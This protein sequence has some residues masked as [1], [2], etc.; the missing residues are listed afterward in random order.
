MPDSQNS[1]E[2]YRKLFTEIP[3]ST[4]IHDIN[5]GEIIDANPAAYTSFGY[6]SLEE[7]QAN[8]IWSEPPYSI[9]DAQEW[10]KKAISKGPQEFEWAHKIAGGEIMW[11]YVRLSPVVINGVQRVMSASINITERK[12]AEQALQEKTKE[13]E[14]SHERFIMAVNGSQ[15]GIWDWDMLTNEVFFSSRWKEMIGY[16]E[17]EL[18]NSFS[19]FEE[20]IHPEDKQRVIDQLEKYLRKEIPEYKVEFQ[21]EHKDGNYTWI[22]ARGTAQWDENGLPYRMSG[23]HTDITERRMSVMELQRKEVQLRTA[24]SVGSIGSWEFDLN[25]RKVDASEEARKIYGIEEKE[26]N[27]DEIQ[28]IPLPEYRPILL[29]TMK[30]LLDKNIPYDVEFKI[31]RPNDGEIRY[32]HSVAEYFAERNVVIGTIQDITESKKN[33]MALIQAKAL[34]EESNQIK[35]EFI[36][37]MSHELRTPL[38]SVIGFSQI[39][40]EKIYGNLNEKQIRYVSNILKSGTHLLELINDILDISKIESGNMDYEPEIINIQ[41]VINEIVVLMDPL[42]KEKMLDFEASIE[43]G[44]PDVKAD[45][46]KIKQIVY[47]LLSNAIKFTPEKGKVWLDSKTINGKVRISVSDNGIGIPFEQQKVIFDPFKQVNSASNRTHGG[48]GLGLA[49]VKYYV[50]MHS[51]EIQVES[52][53]G[54]GSTF[55]FTLPVDF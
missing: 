14:K 34:A 36:A 11:L 27:V 22:L 51:G 39:L 15:D 52:E 53:P 19:A 3:I 5:S 17:H 29:E 43:N 25:F 55:T 37:N 50:E 2:Q 6:S 7:L 42:I 41:E 35:S 21:L 23:S 8:D 46:T 47:N 30:N 48:T 16:K 31:K 20:R 45:K 12:K 38:N 44:N 1:D 18:E 54:K 9:T 32:I 40:N 33:E 24:Q 10:I 26:Y 28:S 4:M 49:I 13:L